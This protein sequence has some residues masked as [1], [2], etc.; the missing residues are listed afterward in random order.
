MHT[1]KRLK[2]LYHELTSPYYFISYPKCG[3]TWVRV[4]LANYYSYKTGKNIQLVNEYPLPY[5]PKIYFTHG[6]YKQ[7]NEAILKDI[8]KAI[9]KKIIFMQR[10][11]KDVVVSLYFHYAKRFNTPYKD[12]ISEFIRDKH[13]GIEK[14]ILYNQLWK[15]ALQDKFEHFII[16]KYEDL[17]KDPTEE[18]DKLLFFIGE[19]SNPEALKCAV[20]Q[21]SFKKMQHK[22]RYQ[23]FQHPSLQPTNPNDINSYKVRRG[24]IGGYKDYLSVEDINYLERWDS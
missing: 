20:E 7:N 2:K 6:H 10:D 14:V 11:P 18:F 8:D 3:R 5:M 15:M 12:T 23:L 19:N 13:V 22:E 17:A 16:L 9:N 1:I 4:F 24:V 21:S